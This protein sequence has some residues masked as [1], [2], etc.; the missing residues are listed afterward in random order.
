MKILFII[1]TIGF[2]CFIPARAGLEEKS[3][4]LGFMAGEPT[5]I[6][7]KKW[8]S[9]INAIDGLI[10]WYSGEYVDSFTLQIGFLN[11]N[12]DE[13]DIEWGKLPFY[14]GAGTRLIMERRRVWDLYRFRYDSHNRLG[15][16][17]VVGMSYIFEMI[18]LEIFMEIGPV[19]DVVPLTEINI[20]YGM[21]VR[22]YFR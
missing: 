10:T 18:P 22:Y 9:E 21:G 1:I 12:F 6:S 13:F 17:G 20:T 4:G 11:H 8:T 7:F 19:I 3:I 5:G 14:F 16:R 15:V 2:L